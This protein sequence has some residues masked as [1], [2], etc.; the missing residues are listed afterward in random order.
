M[1]IAYLT[2][3]YAR[4]SDTFIRREVQ[5]L[6]E[7]GHEVHTYSARRAPGQDVS[8]DV[9]REQSSTLYLT[10]QPVRDLA[11]STIRRLWKKPARFWGAAKSAA[12]LGTKGVKNRV[13]QVAY[14]ME[15]SR[16]AE[17]LEARG[18]EHLHNHL[19]QAS[20]TV[21]L[22]AS[23]MSGIPYS[24]TVHGPH[25]FFEPREQAL[26]AKVSRSAFTACITE[27]CKS[28]VKIFTPY[29]DWGRLEI[30]H[31]G[32]DETFLGREP[33]PVPDTPK[34]V[35][36]GRL[37]EE[38]GQMELIEVVAALTREGVD[39]ELVVVGDG[40]LRAPMEKLAGELGVEKR[41]DFRG[42][43]SS[44]AVRAA[45]EES[46]VMLH[47]SF[48]EGLPVVLMEALALGRP[49]VA[50]RVAGIP[51]LVVDGESGWVVTPGDTQDTLRALRRALSTPPGALSEMGRAGR[52]RVQRDHDNRKETSKLARLIET[53]G[54]RNAR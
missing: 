49:V 25:I 19:A 20:A 8:E 16:L 32:L 10:E 9:R 54:G 2:S 40:P 42:W 5:G 47:P 34:V 27:F 35:T 6:R 3:Q 48:A 30:V 37:C 45:I 12:G 1:K 15:A 52:E 13:W 43:Q 44:E 33:T 53:R 46:R 22:L 18:V 24:M 4:A 41:V 14:I 31:C 36:V 7:M 21:A 38:K 51:E 50:S 23:E 39:I 17:D 26:G 11:A 29:K 28:Q